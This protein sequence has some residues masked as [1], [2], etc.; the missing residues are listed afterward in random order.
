MG[1]VSWNFFFFFF[2]SRGINAAEA[3]EILSK[4]IL[5]NKENYT[6]NKFY[7]F[8]DKQN[9]KIF[10]SMVDYVYSYMEEKNI[11]WEAA[12]KELC[13]NQDEQMI[14]GLREMLVPGSVKQS[15]IAW[16]PATFAK[17]MKQ[18]RTYFFEKGWLNYDMRPEIIRSRK[19]LESKGVIKKAKRKS[20]SKK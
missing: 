13:K 5:E 6:S 17:R 8:G 15:Q 3:F 2:E 20:R 12:L 7:I 18:W 19:A 4:H 14:I 16:S 9:R 11:K 10:I 1:R